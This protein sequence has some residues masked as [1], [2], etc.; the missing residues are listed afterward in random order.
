MDVRAH[1]S[2]MDKLHYERAD[3]SVVVKNQ[4]TSSQGVEVGDLPGG[5]RQSDQAVFDLF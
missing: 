5:K 2:L 1:S 3:Y 4:G